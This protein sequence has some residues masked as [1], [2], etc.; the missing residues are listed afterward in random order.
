MGWG[1][2]GSIMLGG[3]VPVIYLI[4]LIAGPSDE[5][6]RSWCWWA[7]KI[8]EV[9]FHIMETETKAFRPKFPGIP[10][11]LDYH[12]INEEGWKNFPV[13]METRKKSNIDGRALKGLADSLGCS[14]QKRLEKVLKWIAEGAEIGCVGPA[15]AP[16]FSKNTKDAYKVGR[17]VTD[18]I[19][20]WVKDKYVRGPV[21]EEEVPHEAKINSIL[22]R[23]K[24]NGS[25]RVIL[26]LS[27]PEG[28][29]VNDGIDI[30]QFPAKMSSTNAW[31]EVLNKAGKGCWISKTDWSDA[32]KHIAV[33]GSDLNLQWF[34]WGGMYFQELCLIFG[35]A[36]SAGIYDAAAKT[37]L[38]IVCRKANFRPDMVCQHL[39]DMVAAAPHESQSLFR[40]TEAYKYVANTTGVKLAPTDDP[41]KAFEPCKKGVV[42]GVE[43]D[44][45]KW[46]W[47]LPKAKLATINNSILQACE[48]GRITVRDAQKLVGKLVHIKPLIPSGKYNFF[49]VMTLSVEA[50]KGSDPR[51][52]IELSQPCRQQ[53]W[54][55]LLMLKACQEDVSI[56]KVPMY[57]PPWALEAFTDAAGGTVDSL[58]RGTGGVLGTW[59]FYY[60]W[61]KRVASG[62]WRIDGIKVG[63]KLSAL[64]LI[65][66]LIVVVAGRHLLKGGAL[67]IWVD[68]AGSVAIWK[69]GYST[70]CPLSSSI[71]ATIAAVA[72]SL[73]IKIEIEKITRCSNTGAQ[74]A[75]YLSKADFN[76]FR[77]TATTASWQLEVEPARITGTL[78]QWLDKPTVDF[79]LATKLIRE[80]AVE[81]NV[82]GF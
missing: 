56:P 50:N 41:D 72:A 6:R 79:D 34:E 5:L 13:N 32:Y 30:D 67:K 18:A 76:S 3:W 2:G 31:L 55:W 73:N 37:V 68:N 61:P 10:E 7:G 44:T 38:D 49:Y 58:G 40:F 29:S 54:F 74:L 28:L 51:R 21:P 42:F 65:G 45:Q 17:Q 12:S 59:W 39:D 15:R 47:C 19:A 27:A 14:D 64:E 78:L 43:Y 20:A 53:L 11:Q 77:Q 33:A 75:D 22:T 9:K 23:L 25:V 82:I 46:T 52:V 70:S 81:E 60:P 71:V 66:P 69:K 24:P 63:R 36:S 26:N 80:I 16:S 35:C 57:L 62:G 4:I 8:K 48:T 1:E